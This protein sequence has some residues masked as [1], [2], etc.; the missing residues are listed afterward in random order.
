MDMPSHLSETAEGGSVLSEESVIIVCC[1]GNSLYRRCG[2]GGQW[3]ALDLTNCSA[4]AGVSSFAILWMTVSNLGAT[5]ESQL[6]SSVSY[7]EYI[8][9]AHNSHSS[10]MVQIQDDFNGQQQLTGF[11]VERLIE[12]MAV[13][14]DEEELMPSRT[15]VSFRIDVAQWSDEAAN[16]LSAAVNN[17]LETQPFAPAMIT[18]G[19][20]GLRLF[21]LSGLNLRHQ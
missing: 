16:E 21:N 17:L 20:L 11:S 6:Q 3:T 1:W 2:A 10:Y 13:E 5:N 9:K 19:S 18:P 8:M 14:Q 7:S 4:R 12:T 15:H